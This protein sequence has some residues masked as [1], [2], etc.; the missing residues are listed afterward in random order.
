MSWHYSYYVLISASIFLSQLSKSIFLVNNIRHCHQ[1][2]VNINVSYAI[3]GDPLT[4][5]LAPPTSHKYYLYGRNIKLS[6]EDCR[7]INWA[8]SCSPEDEPFP[9]WTLH[10]FCFQ[11]QKEKKRRGRECKTQNAIQQANCNKASKLNEKNTSFVHALCNC[12]CWKINLFYA[13]Y[14]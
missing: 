1:K 6:W 9:L 5:S 13:F 3:F 10:G 4:F 2:R 8:H 12:F 14:C 11:R 7:E